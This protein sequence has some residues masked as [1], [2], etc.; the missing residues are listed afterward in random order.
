[1]LGCTRGIYSI[2]ARGLGP[3]PRVFSQV[4]P[5]TNMPANSA[6]MGLFLC[7][8]WLFYFYGANLTDNWFGFFS[9]DSSELPIITIYA[10][11]IPIFIMFMKKKGKSL[12]FST[13][14]LCP[15]Y[16]LQAVYL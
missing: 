13:G 15:V 12:I 14:S 10:L 4:D 5:A 6:I 9:F 8:L 2:A 16:P 1:M 11:Y 7:S 3:K